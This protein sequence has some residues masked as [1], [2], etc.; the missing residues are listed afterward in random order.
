MQF[1]VVSLL[2]LYYGSRSIC[3]SLADF[4]VS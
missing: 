2:F 1:F 4:S 3:W